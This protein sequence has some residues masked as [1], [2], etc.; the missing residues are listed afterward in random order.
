MALREAG[1]AKNFLGL[2]TRGF[3]NR[4]VRAPRRAPM[5][6]GRVIAT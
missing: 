2:A 6:L 1:S 5:P 3:T 4:P